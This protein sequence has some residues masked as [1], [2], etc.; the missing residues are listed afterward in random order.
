MRTL[1]IIFTLLASF[2]LIVT[3][4]SIPGLPADTTVIAKLMYAGLFISCFVFLHYT[5]HQY[6]IPVTDFTKELKQKASVA[7]GDYYYSSFLN[8]T[9]VLGYFLLFFI[10]VPLFNENI[11]IDISGYLSLS[12]LL[13]I[14]GTASKAR[15][16]ILFLINERS[17]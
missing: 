8:G 13:V 7:S 11:T 3:G 12:I 6:L 5:F 15:G 17:G 9:V 14:F 16:I 4:Q 1:K 10:L 2:S